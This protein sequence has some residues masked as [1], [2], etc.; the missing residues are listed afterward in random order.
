MIRGLKQLYNLYLIWWITAQNEYN[1]KDMSYIIN[2][3]PAVRVIIFHPQQDNLLTP[4]RW[5]G[6][7]GMTS[8]PSCS[9]NL[10]PTTFLWW[11]PPPPPKKVPQNEISMMYIIV[12]NCMMQ[13]SHPDKQY[14]SGTPVN[15][16]RKDFKLVLQLGTFTVL[17]NL[18]HTNRVLLK[19]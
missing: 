18:H 9:P 13:T 10:I 6:C 12:L 7:R 2:H 1:E 17:T 19:Q 16:V 14:Q 4:D 11:W 3:K 15:I 8:W 5:D